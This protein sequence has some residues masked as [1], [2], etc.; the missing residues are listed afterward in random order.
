MMTVAGAD[1][2]SLRISNVNYGGPQIAAL[3]TGEVDAVLADDATVSTA[4][5]IGL[6]SAYFSLLNDPPAQFR[7]MVEA[8]LIVNA[9]TLAAH[10]D[11]PGRL[12][13]ALERSATWMK[14]PA[15]IDELHRITTQVVGVP[16]APDLRERLTV[17]VG[18]IQARMD[19]AQLER[20]LNFVYDT[21]QVAPEPRVTVDQFFDPAMIA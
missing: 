16:D 1:P 18:T 6:G 14:D 21:K 4:A 7:N 12:V 10:P 13:R 20:S 15:N 5:R 19:R 9:S 11:L 3:Q 8:G 2:A 17:L